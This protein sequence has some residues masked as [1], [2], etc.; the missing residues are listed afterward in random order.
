MRETPERMRAPMVLT[1][2][3]L[4]RLSPEELGMQF[5]SA[6]LRFRN[7]RTSSTREMTL[8]QLKWLTDQSKVLHV[9]KQQI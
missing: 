5:T 7:A 3:Q 1:T 4:A 9:T 2:T 6:E 8:N